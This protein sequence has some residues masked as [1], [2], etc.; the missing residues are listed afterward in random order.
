VDIFNALNV[1][2]LAQVN[3]TWGP[4]WGRPQLILQGRFL[5]VGMELDF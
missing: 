5:R 1:S 4:N 2:T 3:E